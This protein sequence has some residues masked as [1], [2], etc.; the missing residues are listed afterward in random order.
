VFRRGLSEVGIIAVIVWIVFGGKT[1]PEVE[2]LSERELKIKRKHFHN[3]VR[4]LPFILL[5]GGII[6]WV[7]GTSTHVRPEE[8]SDSYPF[9]PG[10]NG[11]LV[12]EVCSGC[13]D[14]TIVVMKKYDRESA[15][16]Y[17]KSMVG[18]PDSEQGQKVIEY[19][20]TVLGVK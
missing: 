20:T 8:I 18:D 5:I 2:A 16:R 11:K 14:S 6:F 13:H 7:N 15:R 4:R 12:K 19:L 3:M 17:Y 10:K 1:P 9:P